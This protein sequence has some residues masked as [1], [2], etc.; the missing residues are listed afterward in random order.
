MNQSREQTEVTKL[1]TELEETKKR[2]ELLRLIGDRA[3]EFAATPAQIM[4]LIERQ[5]R[6]DAGTNRVTDVDSALGALRDK[7]PFVM[8]DSERPLPAQ[9]RVH[10]VEDT[11][12]EKLLELFGRNANSKLAHKVGKE[13]P[14]LY[15]RLKGLAIDRGLFGR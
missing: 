15:R 12:D 4:T 8:R 14:A 10:T 3:G 1:Q 9:P 2:A 13:N 6:W 7:Y 11:P 5:V